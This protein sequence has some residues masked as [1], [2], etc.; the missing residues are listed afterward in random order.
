MFLFA[1]IFIFCEN[2]SFWVKNA[3]FTISESKICKKN[4]KCCPEAIL[5]VRKQHTKFQVKMSTNNIAI[6]D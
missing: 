4:L 3:F 2:L 1:K 5:L 6:D